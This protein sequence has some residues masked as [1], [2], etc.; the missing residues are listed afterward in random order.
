MGTKAQSNLKGLVITGFSAVV[1]GAAGM[2][3]LHLGTGLD[4]LH[5][6]I[7]E[8]AFQPGGWLLGAS[9]TS[10]AI[11]AAL[12]SAAM[13][14][15]AGCRRVAWLVAAWGLCMFLVGTFP[16]DPPG[17]AMSMSGEIHRYAALVA[18]LAMPLA[19]LLPARLLGRDRSAVAI[20]V[21]SG[22]AL[23]CLVSVLVPYALRFAG[24]PMSNEDIPAG[25]TQR[26][27]VVTELGVLVL[28]GRDLLVRAKGIL[29]PAAE[30]AERPA[31]VA[32]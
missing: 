24:I 15:A 26:L 25:L 12:F 29:T 6:L 18:F 13:I 32:A 10:F 8:Y 11:G 28:L 16:T 9:L 7:S 22:I 4:P 30:R 2:L 23:V 17:L 21:L 19:G 1:V 3:G 27:V 31:P 14:R 20:R 5:G